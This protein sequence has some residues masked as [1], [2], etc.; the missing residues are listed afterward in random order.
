MPIGCL[1]SLPLVMNKLISKQPKTVLDLG[2]GMGMYGAAVRQWLDMGF[3]ENFS[4]V[5]VGVE[6]FKKY[7]N[8]CW[9]LYDAVYVQSI[10]NFLQRLETIRDNPSPHSVK[11][12]WLFDAVIMTDVLEHFDKQEGSAVIDRI[13]NCLADG[14]VFLLSTPAIHCEQGAVYGNEFER[15]K[16]VWAADELLEFIAQRPGYEI[17]ILQD[18]KL[19]SFG[20][21]MLTACITKITNSV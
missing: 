17:E 4:V 21:M 2:I 18:G 10:Q 5:L 15:H 6:G 13:L 19:D 11:I 16:C 1:S 3:I 7:R 8:P 14:G 12:P 20:T 9:S